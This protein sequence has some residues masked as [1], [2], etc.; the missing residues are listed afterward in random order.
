MTQR[1]S[2]D[3][4]FVESNQDTT[5]I[6]YAILPVRGKK[7]NQLLKRSQEVL[8]AEQKAMSF[9]KRKKR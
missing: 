2:I 5:L 4:S 6:G 8:E 3:E 1:I 9:E 7:K